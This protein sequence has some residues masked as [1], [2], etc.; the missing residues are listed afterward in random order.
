MQAACLTF[1]TAARLNINEETVDS[2]SLIWGGDVGVLPIIPSCI[3]QLEELKQ[4]KRG[5]KYYQWSTQD[6][7]DAVLEGILEDM[8]SV[9]GLI[10]N[11]EFIDW[12]LNFSYFKYDPSLSSPAI[13]YGPG[14]SVSQKLLSN[15]GAEE[16][17]DINGLRIALN[18][19]MEER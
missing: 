11:E 17:T 6:Q 8:E 18:A 1:A 4:T 19:V 16:I 5:I 10:D 3:Q 9:G 13:Q 7:Q 15:H 12:V 2:E 14:S